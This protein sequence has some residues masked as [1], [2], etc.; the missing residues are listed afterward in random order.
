MSINTRLTLALKVLDQALQEE[1]PPEP[2]FF[3]NLWN[4]VNC[5]SHGRTTYLQNPEYVAN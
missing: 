3:K 5:C 2:S 1:L 4:H